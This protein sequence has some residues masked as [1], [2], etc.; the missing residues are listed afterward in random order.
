MIRV[1][2]EEISKRTVVVAVDE[3]VT[4]V[5]IAR[6]VLSANG[7]HSVDAYVNEIGSIVV[8]NEVGSGNHSWTETEV[9]VG[10]PTTVQLRAIATTTEFLK[11][12]KEA[13]PE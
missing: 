3:Q 7:I 5:Q 11:L 12:L 6:M 13:R 1:Q 2:G 9:L 8:D 4:A 10:S